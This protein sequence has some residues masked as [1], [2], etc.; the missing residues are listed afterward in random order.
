[1]AVKVTVQT[2]GRADRYGQVGPPT[3]VREYPIL[4]HWQDSSVEVVDG[5]AT[6]VEIR[7]VLLPPRAEISAQD[8]LTLHGEVYQVRGK[9]NLLEWETG[10]REGWQ[11][12]IEGVK[13]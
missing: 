8:T 3:N 2:P 1:M 10:Q 7:Y 11:V 4:G 13:G 5:V 12:R 9:P 6:V